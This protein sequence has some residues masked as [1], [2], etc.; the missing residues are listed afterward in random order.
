MRRKNGVGMA[1][2]LGFALLILFIG[3]AILLVHDEKT[4]DS[5]MSG[6]WGTSAAREEWSVTETTEWMNE[7][8]IIEGDAAP[9]DYVEYEKLAESEQLEEEQTE[10]FPFPGAQAARNN[11]IALAEEYNE[12][13]PFGYQGRSYSYGF[14]KQ[15]EGY[16]N[17]LYD[18]CANGLGLDGM[19]YA[20]W[21]YR[22][23]MGHTPEELCGE[24]SLQN[25][26]APVDVA[27]LAVGDFCITG[28]G[29]MDADY[30]VVCGFV[31]GHPVVTMC[32]NVPNT[33]FAYGCN[34][35]SYISQEYDEILGSYPAVNFIRFYRLR[36]LS[37]TDGGAY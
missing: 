6:E 1:V 9:E 34:H 37:G 3:C 35:L 31:D 18:N 13:I 14:F 33:K 25:F 4:E 16:R 19:G 15:E 8:D 11:L 36:E 7:G 21:L 10:L 30:G 29:V 17:I 32:D 12:K 24:F 2:V 23:A 5:D 22:N 27:E 28:D 20:I 26:S